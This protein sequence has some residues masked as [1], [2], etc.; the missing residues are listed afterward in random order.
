MS[1]D[2]H[3]QVSPHAAAFAGKCPQCG[4]GA[5]YQGILKPADRCSACGLDLTQLD[6]GDGPAV[7]AMFIVGFIIMPAAVW[8]ELSMQPPIWVHL[9]LW[10]PL[11]IGLSILFLRLMKSWLIADQYKHKAREGQLD[12]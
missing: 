12:T 7:F 11:T 6:M 3:A 9:V 2:Q 4:K 5:L 8:L 1:D 10:S